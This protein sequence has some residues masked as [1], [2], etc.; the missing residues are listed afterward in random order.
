MILVAVSAGREFYRHYLI[1]QE[2]Q[3]LERQAKELE[4][5]RLEILDLAQKIQGGEFLEEEARLRLGL[6]KEGETAV[7]VKNLP[8][9][10]QDQKELIRS[11]S[12]PQLWLDYFS[13]HQIK[14]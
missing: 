13:N 11:R 4:T 7:V 8:T 5:R 3:A 14:N 12:N 2:I 6:Q 10:D 9:D 1:Q